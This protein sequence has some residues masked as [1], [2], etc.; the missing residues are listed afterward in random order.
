[1]T[2]HSVE[3]RQQSLVQVENME[4][5]IKFLDWVV[6]IDDGTRVT[7]HAG[8]SELKPLTGPLTRT[9]V[10]FSNVTQ[11]Q[12]ILWI[13]EPYGGLDAFVARIVKIMQEAGDNISYDIPAPPPVLDSFQLRK[14]MV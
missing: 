5:V 9:F 8:R 2:T 11:E 6:T 12:K 1:M 3:I 13:F 4:N 10:D 14:V 7:H